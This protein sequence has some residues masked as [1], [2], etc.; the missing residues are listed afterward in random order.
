M[1]GRFALHDDP[2]MIAQY[3]M[4]EGDDLGLIQPVENLSL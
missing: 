3:F 2:L 4:A 1:C